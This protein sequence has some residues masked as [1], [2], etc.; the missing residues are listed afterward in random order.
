MESALT[1]DIRVSVQ[2]F[3]RPDLSNAQGGEFVFVYNI[4]IENLGEEKVQLIS[5]HWHIR[6]AIGNERI[7]EG[8]GVVGQQP[9]IDSGNAHIYSSSCHL[10]TYFGTMEGYY[11]FLRLSDHAEFTAKIPL[12]LME[13]PFLLS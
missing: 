1:K 12:F 10:T 7:V 8:D 6:D 2:N 3:Y 5:R 11:N 9:I 4:S 13:V